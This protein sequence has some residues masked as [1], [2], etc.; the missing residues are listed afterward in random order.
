MHLPSYSTLKQSANSSD[1]LRDAIK[2]NQKHLFIVLQPN[3]MLGIIL[4]KVAERLK[5]RLSHFLIHSITSN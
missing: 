4:Y 2:K 5:T 1:D 3:N